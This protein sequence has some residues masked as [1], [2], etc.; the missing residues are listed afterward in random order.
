MSVPPF[1]SFSKIAPRGSVED[2]TGLG[3]R[4][5]PMPTV[6]RIGPYR[7]FF[8]SLDRGE[9]PHIHVRRENRVAKFWLNPIAL[10][11]ARGFSRAELTAI[12]RLVQENREKFLEG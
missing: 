3:V 10:Q 4:F 7:F 6:L 2:S 12:G 5:H 1:M 9:P 8:V 11:Q